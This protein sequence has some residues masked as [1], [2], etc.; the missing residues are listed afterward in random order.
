MVRRSLVGG[1]ASLSSAGGSKRSAKTPP[2]SSRPRNTVSVGCPEALRLGEGEAWI[3]L[4]FCAQQHAISRKSVGAGGRVGEQG[5]DD[6]LV[7]AGVGEP[8]ESVMGI[9][10]C[11]V[12]KSE[13]TVGH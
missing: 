12:V 10:E 13:C 8:I 4:A 7:V 2:S 5:G 11:S 1:A 3:G 6:A 9:A